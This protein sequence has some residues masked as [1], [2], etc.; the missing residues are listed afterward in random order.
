MKKYNIAIFHYIANFTDGVSLEM[1][2]WRNVFEEMGHTTHLCAGK[3]GAAEE[4]VI[5][6]MYHH[7]PDAR[8][9]NFNTFKALREYRD[10]KV[11]RTEMYRLARIIEKKIN[12]FIEE[13]KI[14]F[15]VPQNVWSVAAN[16]AVAIALTNIMRAKKIP[17]LAHN[18]DFYFERTDGF[19]LTCSTAAEIADRYLPP[20]DPLARHVVINSLARDQLLERKGIPA[21][22][23]PNVFDFDS[24]PWSPD[25]YNRDLRERIGLRDNDIL[26]LQATRLV[27]RKGIELGIEFVSALKSPQRRARLASHG[28]FDGRQFSDKNR[29]V[30]VLAGFAMDDVT[31]RYK[32]LLVH[33]ADKMNVD[34][35]FIEDLVGE[36]REIR[37]GKK[38]YSL[39][40]TYVFADFVTYPSQWEG[41][42]NQLLEAIRAKLPVMLFEYPVFEADIKDKGLEVVSLGNEITGHD[43]HGLVTIDPD[44]IEFA[45]DQAVD[46]LTNPTLRKATVEHNFQVGKRHF[47]MDALYIY[48][49][50]LMQ[51]IDSS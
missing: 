36:S 45:A 2:K 40:D 50:Q 30:F 12:D 11:Y 38:I 35:V 6:E 28:L 46:F 43:K 29:I 23:V 47:S 17:A 25:D 13:K 49:E 37:N 31:G 26:V 34:A 19:A 33:K 3:Y 42:G 16:P 20:R 9:L 22:I 5:E 18:H 48:L 8:L 32:N 4:M 27:T 7:S 51:S 1:N 39:W 21:S 15:L 10:E 44:I 41:W 14:D 24:P